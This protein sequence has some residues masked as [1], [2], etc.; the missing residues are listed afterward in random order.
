[1][2]TFLYTLTCIGILAGSAPAQPPRQTRELPGAIAAAM[3]DSLAKGDFIGAE[4]DFDESFKLK[5]PPEKL[6]AAWRTMTSLAGAYERQLRAA[7]EE[8]GQSVRVR[9]IC[10]FEKFP[11]EV[12]VPFTQELRINGFSFRLVYTGLPGYADGEKFTEEP[13]SFSSQ[14]TEL[15]GTLTLPKGPGPFKAVLLVHGSGP[16]DQ[17][18]TI[19]PNKPFRDI[20][21]GLASRGTAVF[22]YEKRRGIPPGIAAAEYTVKEEVINDALAAAA[23]LRGDRRIARDGLYLMGHSLGGQLAPWIARL[24]GNMAGVISAAGLVKPLGETMLRQKI[25]LK[26]LDGTVTDEER[27][28]IEA[29]RKQAELIDGPELNE[30]TP[31][32]DLP[33]GLSPEYFLTLR[34]YEPVGTAAGLKLPLLILQGERDYQVTM[35]DFRLWREGLAGKADAVLKSYPGLNHHFIYGEGPGGPDE[36]LLQGNVA[37]EVITDIAAWLK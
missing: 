8:A 12:T 16:N 33:G 32:K 37:E 17:D 24:D 23:A 25:Y 15:K 20:A 19:G 29:A 28:E 18:S 35:D 36:Y 13:L 2:R 27:A 10:D 31:A 3:I 9:I 34:G 1:M 22:R 6:Q 26:G 4:R 21:A 5:V 11:L 30:N 14:G 7:T